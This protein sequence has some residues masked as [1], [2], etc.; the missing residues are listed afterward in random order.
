MTSFDSN[1]DDRFANIF[2][3]EFGNSHTDLSKNGTFSHFIYTAVVIDSKDYDKAKKIR[4]DICHVFRLG[5]NIKSSNIKEKQFDKRVNILK[6]LVENLDFTINS[7]I[8]DKSAITSEGLKNK[9]VFYK[10]FES[11]FVAKYNQ[12]FTRYHIWSDSIGTDFRSELNN[13]IQTNAIQRD[14]FYPDRFFELTDDISGEKLVQVADFISGCVGKIF[15]A[16]HAHEKARELFQVIQ[17][18]TS[19]E[20]F[21][22]DS[23]PIIYSLDHNQTIDSEIRKINLQ[24]ISEHLNSKNT[25]REKH[26]LLNYLRL[27]NEINPSRLTPTHE[28]SNYIEQFVSGFSVEKLRTL[29]RDLRFEG[30][31]IISHSGK[32]GYKLANSYNDIREHFNHFLKYVVP[33]LNKVKI[34]NDSLSSYSFNKINPIEKDETLKRLR[35]LLMALP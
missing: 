27:Q 10:Y 22:F 29:I 31:F 32:P 8:V 11:L 33:M 25:S 18:R 23:T 26:L 19:V 30:I 15:C 6:Y 5:P 20:Y 13:Y 34:I 1:N 24:S 7:L 3:D 35:E 14:L 21:P 17:P 12:K 2:I 16:S 4:E 9:K 28:L